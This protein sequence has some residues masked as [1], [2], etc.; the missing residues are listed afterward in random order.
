[1]GLIYYSPSHMLS[2]M[3]SHVMAF[4]EKGAVQAR[5]STTIM[6]VNRSCGA[7]NQK[8]NWAVNCLLVSFAQWGR[9]ILSKWTGR[10]LWSSCN[11]DFHN[12]LPKKVSLLYQF[13]EDVLALALVF[14]Y[15]LSHPWNSLIWILESATTCVILIKTSKNVDFNIARWYCCG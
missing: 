3:G 12:V 15:Y 13:F 11:K 14:V 10:A 1:M 2:M 7:K 9:S 4:S 6:E 8:V 5:A